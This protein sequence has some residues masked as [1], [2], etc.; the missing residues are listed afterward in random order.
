MPADVVELPDDGLPIIERDVVRLI[1]LDSDGRVLLLETRDAT[2]PAAEVVWQL[3]GGG[4]EPE[5][6]WAGA[7][8]RELREETGLN[9][10]A[11][12]VGEARW[13]RTATYRYRGVRRLQHE[14]VVMVGLSDRQPQVMNQ[15]GDRDEQDDCI[16]SRWWLTGEIT[17][18]TLR[19]YPGRLP[20]LLPGVLAG[21]RV[22]EPFELWS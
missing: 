10:Q 22:I 9:V 7:A 11:S 13:W 16:G 2:D 21:E 3:P 15:G 1:V 18:S 19:F 8:V 12:T 17:S 5:E 20:S 4:I 6:D 14:R